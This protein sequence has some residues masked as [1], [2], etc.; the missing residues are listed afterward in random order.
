MEYF[1]PVLIALI[2]IIPSLLTLIISLINNKNTNKNNKLKKELNLKI[3]KINYNFNKNIEDIHE[4]IVDTRIDN[5]RRFLVT[6]LTEILNG[7]I[8]N[9]EQKSLIHESYDIYKNKYG[10]NS[11]VH[12]LYKKCIEKDLI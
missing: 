7:V 4:I 8:K 12:S 5:L 3:D 2:G 11:Y 6:Q 1:I 10:K 9:D